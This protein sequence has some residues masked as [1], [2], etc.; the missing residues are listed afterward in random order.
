MDMKQVFI[1]VL[2][3]APAWTCMV[4]SDRCCD[5]DALLRT[6]KRKLESRYPQPREVPSVADAGAPATCP[7]ELYQKMPLLDVKDR[8]ISPWRYV[9]VTNPDHFPHTY[10]EA[11]CLCQGC[12][13]VHE[14]GSVVE[15]HDY[16]SAVIEQ[17]RVFL[18][19]VPCPNGEGYQLMPVSQQVAVGCTCA[20][21][22]S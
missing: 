21:Y 22:T 7:L 11:Q 6:A 15:S 19:R 2:L 4:N 20:R 8:S 16:N 13:L 9:T 5:E 10:V 12:I 18:K 17:T 3:L 1:L 14:N